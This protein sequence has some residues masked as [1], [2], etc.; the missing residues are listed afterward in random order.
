MAILLASTETLFPLHLRFSSFLT[1]TL[2]P[3]PFH[4]LLHMFS[5]SCHSF[6]CYTTTLFHPCCFLV[7]FFVS[8]PHYPS[9]GTLQLG[10][11]WAHL[12]DSASHPRFVPTSRIFRADNFLLGLFSRLVDAVGTVWGA[13]KT[14]FQDH[15]L[16]R[17]VMSCAIFLACLICLLSSFFFFFFFFLHLFLCSVTSLH[18]PHITLSSLVS[19]YPT[20]S[21]L[22]HS[23]WP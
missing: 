10:N 18:S 1:L 12:A 20:H 6:S 11:Q 16:P 2:L 15:V 3:P 19:G 7:L 23:S 21:S 4:L 22:L 17:N 13:A 9:F 8:L 5:S 14:M